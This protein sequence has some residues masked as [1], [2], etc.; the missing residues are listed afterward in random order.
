MAIEIVSF[1]FKLVMFNSYVKLPEG[2][3]IKAYGGVLDEDNE[4]ESHA[5]VR[6]VTS[7]KTMGPLRQRPVIFVAWNSGTI[8][9]GKNL[10]IP[11]TISGGCW[12]N[13]HLTVE[14]TNGITDINK[15]NHCVSILFLCLPL[16]NRRHKGQ[17]VFE[18]LEQFQ[19]CCANLDH[20][21]C[22]IPNF[23]CS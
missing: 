21:I 3:R 7:T 15:R 23:L 20:R 5:A 18:S 17:I 2:T 13:M 16:K 10:P 11:L 12:S 6:Y 14:M 9:F 1:A 19:L 8:R 22:P 4:F